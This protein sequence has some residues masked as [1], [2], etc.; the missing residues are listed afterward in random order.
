MFGKRGDMTK[1]MTVL[2]VRLLFAESGKIVVQ[3][4]KMESMLKVKVDHCFSDSICIGILYMFVCGKRET[5]GCRGGQVG[6]WPIPT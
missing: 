2:H 6:D 5:V 3:K 4:Q 1:A